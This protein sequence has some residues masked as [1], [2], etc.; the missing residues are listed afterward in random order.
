MRVPFQQ[1]DWIELERTV[2]QELN[3]VHQQQVASGMLLCQF[4]QDRR[5]LQVALSLWNNR[6]AIAQ[7]GSNA[8]HRDAPFFRQSLQ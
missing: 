1:I 7:L 8:E 5:G 2:K 6:E 4:T 3:V